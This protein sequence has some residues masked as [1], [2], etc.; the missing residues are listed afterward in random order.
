MAGGRTLSSPSSTVHVDPG[1]P[2][3]RLPS[4]SPCPGT[5]MTN[6]G[7]T[8]K[9]HCKLHGLF[10][11]APVSR[12]TFRSFYQETRC[13]S[14][15][16][17]VGPSSQETTRGASWPFGPG[18]MSSCTPPAAATRLCGQR[19]LAWATGVHR[20]PSGGTRPEA[21]ERASV[22]YQRG[23]ADGQTELTGHA[24]QRDGEGGGLQLDRQQCAAPVH[25]EQRRQ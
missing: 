24:R 8:D 2:V 22:L 20:G 21:Q 18:S 7:L 4:S 1:A 19:P 16:P 17:A 6:K 14:W 15:Q 11:C 12:W 5:T 25:P 13:C 3:A 9:S 10:P 23:G